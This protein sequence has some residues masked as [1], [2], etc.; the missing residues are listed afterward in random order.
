MK[1]KEIF[2]GKA[3]KESF[4]NPFG[5]TEAM[6][7]ALQKIEENRK[8]FQSEL[9]V[10]LHN[11][12]ESQQKKDLLALRKLREEEKKLQKRLK[13]RTVAART[14]IESGD[15]KPWCS[16]DGSRVLITLQTHGVDLSE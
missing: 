4:E 6:Q 11:F 16:I 7:D 2:S 9:I 3:V 14:L 15:M 1:L 13:G 12:Y 10:G 5:G 8:K